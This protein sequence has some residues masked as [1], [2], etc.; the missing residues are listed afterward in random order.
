MLLEDEQNV[1]RWLTQYGVL[2]RTQVVRLLKDKTTRTAEKIIQN[3]KR[4]HM[5][6]DIRDGYYIGLD[7]LVQCD[8]R[9]I[10]AV[11]VLLKFIDKVEPMAHYAASYPSQLFFLKDEIGYE[12][13]V[14]YDGEQHILRLLRPDDDLKYIIVVPHISMAREMMLPKAPCLFATVNYAGKDEPDVVFYKEEAVNDTTR[15]PI[16]V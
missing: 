10:T 3:L 16:P 8:Q 15:V 4:C 6:T 9:T 1:V 13:I 2:T 14:L 12:I 7:K 5:V 11:W